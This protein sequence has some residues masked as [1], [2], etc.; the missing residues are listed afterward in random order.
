MKK[1][2]LF[3]YLL[4]SVSIF[5][6]P[7]EAGQYINNCPVPDDLQIIKPDGNTVPPKLALLS[8]IW[9]GN[10]ASSAIFVVEQIKENEAVVI[11]AWA[12]TTARSQSGSSFAPGFVRQ[13]CPIERGEDGNYRITLT[14]KTTGIYKLIQTNDPNQIRVLRE[15]YGTIPTQNRDSIFRKKEMK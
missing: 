14:L 9:E 15:G 12:G 11:L 8:G 13:K 5:I 1:I 7:A 3:C 10:W 2:I 6:S 4:V